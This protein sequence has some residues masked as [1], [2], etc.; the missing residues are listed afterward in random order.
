[1]GG[2]CHS[3]RKDTSSIHA[4]LTGAPVY[5]R[6]LPNHRRFTMKQGKQS[7]VE[8]AKEI[9]RQ[10]DS[11]V[12]YIAPA[13]RMEVIANGSVSLMLDRSDVTN[14]IPLNHIASRQLGDKVGIPAKYFDRMLSD[15]PDLF[16]TNVNHWLGNSNA[17]HMI[18]TLDGDV[19][20]VL[21]DRYQRIDNI[22]IGNEILPILMNS[23]SGLE[24]A[25]CEITEK[26]MYIKAIMPQM[27]ADVKVGDTVQ[28][29]ISITNS[30][31]GHGMFEVAPFIMRLVCLNGMKVN[32]A[33][34]GRRHLGARTDVND[35][36]Y[37]VLSNETLKADDKAFM[38]KARDVV[39]AAFEEKL[40]LQHVDA[41]R[42][43]TERKI[44]GNPVKAVEVLAKNNG[45]LQGEQDG[46][47][48][49]L[50][51][52]A[53]LS[54]YGMVQAVTAFSQDVQSYDRASD[55]EELGGKIVTLTDQEWKPIA[56]AA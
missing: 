19:R 27:Q 36:V 23:L 37:N 3:T 55:F 52:G 43:T 9:Q 15:A 8:L 34:F 30:E 46:I 12:D 48:R 38:L 31:I 5:M 56:V 18:R 39:T 26:K 25:S 21:S 13:K 42:Q 14:K 22:D 4:S 10:A 1:V 47:L 49:K 33:A 29:G 44:L 35:A 32:D 6:G 2:S 51:E 17:N 40:F 7:I 41:L 11:K 28:A 53:D 54:Q 24:I 50:I 16:A 20:A 45:L